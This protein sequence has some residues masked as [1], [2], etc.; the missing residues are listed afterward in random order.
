MNLCCRTTKPNSKSSSQIRFT[1]FEVKKKVCLVSL[2]TKFAPTAGLVNQGKLLRNLP[3]LNSRP[4]LSQLW[5]VKI[6][7]MTLLDY[8]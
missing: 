7:T 1:A 5:S 4:T 3:V 6:L 2:S 8:I